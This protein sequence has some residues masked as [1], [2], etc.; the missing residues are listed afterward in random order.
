MGNLAR[1]QSVL[2]LSLC[3][4]EGLFTSRERT[5]DEITT[6]NQQC[7]STTDTTATPRRSCDPL[8]S[9]QS[10]FLF[11]S[12][13]PLSLFYFG[14]S[15][16]AHCSWPEVSYVTDQT[17]SEPAVYSFFMS[18]IL[19]NASNPSQTCLFLCTE[20]SQSFDA[21]APLSTLTHCVRLAHWSHR[22]AR[23]WSTSTSAASPS[24]P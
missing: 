15:K 11:I 4:L 21:I 24:S 5:A 6:P 23:R 17:K 12:I 1:A 18:F 19:L 20:R 10:S 9:D 14:S 16:Y 3:Q 2:G 22:C 13:E 8:N 7:V